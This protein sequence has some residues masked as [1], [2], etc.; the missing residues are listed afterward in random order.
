MPQV[1]L[2]IRSNIPIV[3]QGFERL[4]KAVPEIGRMRLFSA[5]KELVRRMSIPGRAPTYPIRWDTAKQRRSFFASKGFGHGVP[6]VRTDRYI[7]GWSVERHTA[8]SYTVVNKVLHARF[9]GGLLTRDTQSQIH[10]GRWPL[11]RDMFERVVATLPETVSRHLIKYIAR[12]MKSVP[13]ES[14]SGE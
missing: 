2:R 1:T 14:E 5:A 9:V 13:T 12:G 8:H 10:K 7:S 3:R 11:L 4:R 6:A